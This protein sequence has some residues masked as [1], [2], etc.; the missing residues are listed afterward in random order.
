[1]IAMTCDRAAGVI[2]SGHAHAV[3]GGFSHNAKCFQTIG[4]DR[5]TVGFFDSKFLGAAQQR[6]SVRVGGGNEQYRK[7]IDCERNQCNRYLDAF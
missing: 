7:F 2:A 4:H 1:M 5:D 6:D 3:R